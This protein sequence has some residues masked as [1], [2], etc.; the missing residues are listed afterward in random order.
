M[1]GDKY[2]FKKFE[3]HFNR[4][5]PLVHPKTPTSLPSG[6]YGETSSDLVSQTKLIALL[7]QD[8][9]T[10]A[11]DTS[12]NPGLGQLLVLSIQPTTPISTSVSLSLYDTLL[13]L[14]FREVFILILSLPLFLHN[15]ALKFHQN[16][17]Q[18]NKKNFH[19]IQIL[20]N[21]LQCTTL[22]H[23]MVSCHQNSSQTIK[24]L[25]PTFYLHSFVLP[26]S[27]L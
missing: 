22:K 7:F 23:L 6:C 16:T 27:G 9:V 11:Q 1:V 3:G 21:L 4:K 14:F 5:L 20:H 17:L 2:S 12:N 13:L 25:S 19:Y 26:L 8:V 15:F 24:Q 18:F 10:V